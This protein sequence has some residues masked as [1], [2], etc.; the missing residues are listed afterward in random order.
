MGQ[1]KS[2]N[3]VFTLIKKVKAFYKTDVIGYLFPTFG[4]INNL[5]HLSIDEY[6]WQKG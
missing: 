2:G 3:F 1:G 4:P 5:H 6:Y